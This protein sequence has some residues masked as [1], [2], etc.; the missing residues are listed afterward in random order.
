MF[1]YGKTDPALGP[2]EAGKEGGSLVHIGTGGTSTKMPK[3][4]RRRGGEMRKVQ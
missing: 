2:R 4:R 1:G 3:L